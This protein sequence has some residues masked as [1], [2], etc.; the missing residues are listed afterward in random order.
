M[1]SIENEILCSWHHNYQ[2]N[3]LIEGGCGGL[4]ELLMQT[5]E[6]LSYSTRVKVLLSMPLNNIHQ[7]MKF[8]YG[9]K[10]HNFLFFSPSA[11]RKKGT[12]FV[13]VL[14]WLVK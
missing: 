8:T 4:P 14:K 2:K 11:V 12:F 3:S 7:Q 10:Q 1:L 9:M 6:D 13:L 5:Q